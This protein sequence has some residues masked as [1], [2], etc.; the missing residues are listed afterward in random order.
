MSIDTYF[1]IHAKEVIGRF[2]VPNFFYET[3]PD[4]SQNKKQI[5]PNVLLFLP[6]W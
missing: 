2:L 3:R 5:G 1:V 4:K 6:F